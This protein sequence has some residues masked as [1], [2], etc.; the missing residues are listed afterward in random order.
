MASKSCF[1]FLSSCKR[2]T[3]RDKPVRSVI[4]SSLTDHD[5]RN[6]TNQHEGFSDISCDFV[7]RFPES[8]GHETRPKT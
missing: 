4:F 7:D 2:E 3:P 8:D 6:H 5:P 1:G